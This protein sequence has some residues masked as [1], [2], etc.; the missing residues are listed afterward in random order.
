MPQIYWI[1]AIIIMSENVVNPDDEVLVTGGTGYIASHCVDQLLKFG[2]KKVRC[3]VRD[4]EGEK[5]KDLLGA[6]KEQIDA[7]AQITLVKGNLKS[8]E[9]WDEAVKG[10]TFVLHTASPVG[11]FH[12]AK[13]KAA[14][15]QLVEDAVNGVKYVL[16]AAKSSGTVKRVVLTSSLAAIFWDDLKHPP[17]ERHGVH[18]YTEEDWTDTEGFFFKGDGYT[19]SKTSAEKFAWECVEGS[20]V[21]LAVI[22]PVY[23][24]G[25][26]LC[27][28]AVSPSLFLID[29]PMLGKLPRV[30]DIA[31]PCVDVR[32]VGKA[33]VEA[34]VR[35][36]AAGKRFLLHNRN[37]MWPEIIEDLRKDYESK[38]YKLP[39]TKL[40]SCLVSCFACIGGKGGKEFKA[41]IGVEPKFSNKQATEILGLSPYVD[42]KQSV[43]ES[44]ESFIKYDRVAEMQ[45]KKVAQYT[46]TGPKPVPKG[47][48]VAPAK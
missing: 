22:N 11:D 25:P 20:S 45:G 29:M 15:D 33:H 42:M 21:E 13:N 1:I 47:G 44:V 6:F 46:A 35:K 16:E 38:G 32:D 24:L 4:P 2:Y 36:E 41:M 19:R 27:A 3:S 18:V 10:C 12:T 30:V 7:G 8:A 26:A 23:V 9:G 39:K 5:S 40:G 28:S 17:H 37:M 34:M 31:F 43:R 14:Q 48:Q